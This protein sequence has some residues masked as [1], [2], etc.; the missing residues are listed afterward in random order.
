[1]QDI[2]TRKA[3]EFG[4]LVISLD[5]AIHWGVRYRYPARE[6][7]AASLVG[8]RRVIPE[9]L[10]VFEEFG[11]A[12]TWATVGFLFARSRDELHRFSPVL[13]PS[14]ADDS[15]SPYNEEI[16][17]DEGDDPLHYAPSLIAAIHAAPRQEIGTHTFS[18]YYCQ[19]PG[20]D[21]E[22]FRA[23]LASA[24][25]IATHYGV[26]LRSIVF[27][28]NQ[29]NPEYDD[30]LRS[31]G[32]RCYRG[33]T[34][35]WMYSA[36]LLKDG[37]GALMRGGRLLNAYLPLSG[38]RTSRWDRLVQPNGLC[39]LPASLFLKPYSPR[40]RQLESIRVQRIA[41]L[42]HRGA[43]SREIVHLYCHPH[44]FGGYLEGNMSTL[45][46]ILRTFA[47]YRETHGMQSLSMGGVA[48]IAGDVAGQSPPRPA[49]SVE[50]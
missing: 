49:F 17:D 44:N 27:P 42:I 26:Q 7:Y 15:L 28:R 36:T 10:R 25:A 23:D 29:Y 19:E 32:I 4:A 37:K 34:P 43:V 45:R 33:N 9:M 41:S 8:V 35:G 13:R 24:V 46:A 38:L 3:P 31:T 2:D 39:N 40:L 14:Y 20:Q 18:H 48:D 50:R 47:R 5:F 1:M 22:Q 11:I 30:V 16:G 12:A 21:R 6:A